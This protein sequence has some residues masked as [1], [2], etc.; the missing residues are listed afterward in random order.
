MDTRELTAADFRADAS[1]E[2]DGHLHVAANLG[3][4]NCLSIQCSGSLGIEA[5]TGIKAEYGIEAGCDIEAGWGIEAGAG[6]KAGYGIKAGWNIRA[7]WNIEAG[8]GIC[9]GEGIKAGRGIEAVEG[10]EAGSGIKAGL[11][12]EAGEGISCQCVLKWSYQL[13]AGVITWRQST[14]EDRRIVCGRAEGGTVECGELF[15]TGIPPT[16][17]QCGLLK[18][19]CDGNSRVDGG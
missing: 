17:S 10:I 11:G 5:G 6:I 14:P 1:I 15:E 2:C 3:T 18:G 4:L 8:A 7:G 12:I 19:D 13:F 9:A 16:Q